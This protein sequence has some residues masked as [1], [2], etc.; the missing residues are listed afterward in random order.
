MAVLV[1]TAGNVRRRRTLNRLF[2]MCAMV[3]TEQSRL[4]SVLKSVHDWEFD[5]FAL[6]SLAPN[7]SL[8]LVAQTILTDHGTVR[9]FD[10]QVRR[11]G[12]HA[13]RQAGRQT[14]RQTD[15]WKDRKA[16]R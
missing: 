15:R 14:G 7:N 3:E 12:R 9:S 11:T 5:V 10:R 4:N 13:D 8:V 1:T 16:A 2:P 6:H